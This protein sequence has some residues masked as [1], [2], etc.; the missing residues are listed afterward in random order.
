MK[1]QSRPN[2]RPH[3]GK[4]RRTVSI[5]GTGS[6]VPD[7]RLTNDD[8]EDLY[9]RVNVGTH[10]VVLPGSNPDAAAISQHSIAR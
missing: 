7:Q 10:I 9:N 3:T 8:I 2:P 6:Y 1:R 5:V 4:A